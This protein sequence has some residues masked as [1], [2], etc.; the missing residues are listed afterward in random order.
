MLVRDRAPVVDL[1][2]RNDILPP[3]KVFVVS[4]VDYLGYPSRVA[5]SILSRFTE[6]LRFEPLPISRVPSRLVPINYGD[7]MWA[8]TILIVIGRRD[9]YIAF[10]KVRVCE[11]NCSVVCK[12]PQFL[13][14][15]TR[16]PFWMSSARQASKVLV[17]CCDVHER[18]WIGV[19]NVGEDYV[20][21]ALATNMT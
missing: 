11:N 10:I 17:K 20:T 1:P 6:P 5:A 16:I 19:A 7:Q 4:G 14:I 18:P 15:A 8:G 3:I 12:T 13:E 2:T 21:D 9:E